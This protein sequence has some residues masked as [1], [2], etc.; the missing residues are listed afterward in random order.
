[1]HAVRDAGA[2]TAVDGVEVEEQQE[3]KRGRV[4]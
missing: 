2:K 3:G 4:V 1:M